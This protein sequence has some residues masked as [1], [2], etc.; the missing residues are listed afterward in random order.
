MGALAGLILALI[1]AGAT[2]LYHPPGSSWKEAGEDALLRAGVLTPT[3]CSDGD[4]LGNGSDEFAGRSATRASSLASAGAPASK[5]PALANAAAERGPGL[6]ATNPNSDYGALAEARDTADPVSSSSAIGQAA[7]TISPAATSA[8]STIDRDTGDPQSQGEAE[9]VPTLMVPTAA[10]AQS[11]AGEREATPFSRSGVVYPQPP[12]FSLPRPFSSPHEVRAS[13][14]YPFG[15][16]AG[17]NYLM[18]HG[19]DIGN[20]I[21]TPVLAIAKGIVAYAGSDKDDKWGLFPD[22]YGN[23]VV[24]R[25]EL[26]IAD[27]QLHSLYGH[28]SEVLATEGAFVEAGDTLGLVG[29]EGVALG[30]HLHLEMRVDARDYASTRNPQLFL[31]PLEGAGTIIGR[32]TDGRGQPFYEQPISLFSVDESGGHTWTAATTTYPADEIA[33]D[34]IWRENFVFGDW[35]EG[36][37]LV[38]ANLAGRSVEQPVTIYN[39]RASLV[40]LQTAP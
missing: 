21:G 4:E 27:G 2:G 18:H 11:T 38:K 24:V 40:E 12:Y 5:E 30:P 26:E 20:P 1:V 10:N 16:T 8:Q 34:S 39:G 22:F 28:L 25:H 6:A 36:D 33:A 19:V 13:S 35:P 29:A 37:Y 14:Y 3:S 17:G 7:S 31:Q 32:L 9:A 23:L 15:T